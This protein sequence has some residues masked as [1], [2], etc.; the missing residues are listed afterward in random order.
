MNY[1]TNVSLF[2][3]ASII[4][5]FASFRD[6]LKDIEKVNLSEK[7]IK[8][9]KKGQSLWE[10]ITCSRFKDVIPGYVLIISYI[11]SA[12]YLIALLDII[13]VGFIKGNA[14]LLPGRLSFVMFFS[15]GWMFAYT[16]AG[17]DSKSPH[18]RPEL[19]VPNVKTGKKS[20]KYKNRDEYEKKIFSDDENPE[21]YREYSRWKKNLQIIASGGKIETLEG[22]LLNEAEVRD[23]IKEVKGKYKATENAHEGCA[24]KH[25][26]YVTKKGKKGTIR[27]SEE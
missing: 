5:A 6:H 1:T 11:I 22:G 12:V 9:R 21:V 15:F 7:E 23:L 13:Y 4:F 25:I 20:K 8:S 27:I 2:V 19:W 18:P 24:Y 3:I 17:W 10:W 26:H 14:D 16:A